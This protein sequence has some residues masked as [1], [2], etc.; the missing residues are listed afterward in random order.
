MLK[1]LLSPQSIAIIGGSDDIR[2]PGGRLLSNILERGYEGRVMVVNPKSDSVQ[3]VPAYKSIADMP[4]IPDLAYLAIPAKFVRSSLEDLCAKGGKSAVILS[5]GFGELNE[6]GKA[7][8]RRFKEIA[9]ANDMLLL[10]PN[11][12]GVMTTEV[13]GKF[14]GIL[15]LMSTEG[16]DFLSGSGAT[17][18]YLAEQATKRGLPFNSFMT[19]GNS[20]QTEVTDLLELFDKS[21]DE[22]SS[23][24]KILYME[25][26]NDPQ[27]LISSAKSLA[28]KG[29]HL[30]GIKAGATEAGNRAAASH[31]GALVSSDTAVQAMFDKAGIIRVQSRIE[32]VDIAC[33]MRIAKD[34][35]DGKRV[36]IV[37]DAGGPGVMLADELNR[38]GIEAPVLKAK[39]QARLADALLPSSSMVNPIDCL[40]ARTAQHFADIFKILAEEEADSIDYIMV[41]LGDSGLSDISAIYDVIIKAMD[42]L[43]MPVFPSFCTAVTSAKALS[44]FTKVGKCYFEDEVAMGRALGRVVNRP[45]IAMSSEIPEG[46]DLDRIKTIMDGKT[47]ILDA[48]T[49]ADL[50][51]AAGINLPG[52]QSVMT[53]EALSELTGEFPFPWVM[54]VEGPL[55]KTDVGGVMLNIGDL[56]E[57]QAAF[58]KLMDIPDAVGV[59]VQQMI[60]GTEVIVGIK[61][62]EPFGSLTAFGLG[63]IYAEAMKD[64]Q[65][66]LAP[67]APE[68]AMS[69]INSIAAAPIIKGVRGEQGMDLDILS[70]QIVRVSLLA[71][72]FPQIVEMDINPLKGF[73]SAIYAVDARIICE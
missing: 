22:K 41:V 36:C 20:A 34:K 19:V 57:A 6:E 39:T 60:Q 25:T 5:A 43:P 32:L 47:G 2:K 18:D 12:L 17:I 72:D 48:E 26:V 65:F 73:G 15:P 42:T 4:E 13:A 3:G 50:L 59:L 61:R 9:D 58:D 14:A 10:G 62:E 16:I 67:L 45:Q 52:Q 28:A 46:Y 1:R 27:K 56:T 23:T 70:D 69:M 49:V 55:H 11:C 30:A 29:C 33:I 66:R 31:T 51:T 44:A 63:G 38:Q 24:V 54:K 64:I 7:E 35:L 37:T 71:A 21:Y 40:P 68:E 53:K 8:E